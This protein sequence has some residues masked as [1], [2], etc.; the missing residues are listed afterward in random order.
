M[1][2]S[3]Q[4]SVTSSS[5]NSA[6]MPDRTNG[7]SLLPVSSKDKDGRMKEE[8]HKLDSR[9]RDEVHKLLNGNSVDATD[10]VLEHFL[11]PHVF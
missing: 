8:L 10:R 2:H 11:S 1:Q 3:H 9:M 4:H 7:L 5:A 6:E